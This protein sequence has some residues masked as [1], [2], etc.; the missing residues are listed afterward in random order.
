MLRVGGTARQRIPDQ[1]D[2]HTIQFL[3]QAL[4]GDYTYAHKHMRFYRDRS[5][6]KSCH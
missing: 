3:L 2:Q 1:F 4:V 6:H 5:I